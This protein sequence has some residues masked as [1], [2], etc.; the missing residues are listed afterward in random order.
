VETLF[1]VA[2]ARAAMAKTRY[3]VIVSDYQMPIENGIQFLKSLRG[4]GDHI[5]FIL[6]TGKGREEVVIEALNSGADFY[7]QK[8][9]E[10]TPLYVELEH[11]IRGVVRRHDAEMR[12]QESENRFEQLAEQGRIVTWEVNAHGIFTYVNQ[13]SKAVWGYD[14]GDLIGNSHF[15]D[16]HPQTGQEEFKRS[17]FAVFERKEKLH[18]V[19]N[20]VQTKA[21]ETIWVVT[22]GVPILNANGELKGYRGNDVDATARI[23]AESALKDKEA[24]FRAFFASIGDL[25]LVGTPDGRILFGNDAVRRKLG[26]TPEDLASMHMLDLHPADRRGE[27][28]AIFGA[29]FRGE[30]DHCPLPLAHKNGTLMPAETRVWFGRWDGKD[31]IFGISKDLTSQMEAQQMF[32]RLFRHNP[33]PMAVSRASGEGFSFNSRSLGN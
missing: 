24:N 14:P 4:R 25:I 31:C 13:V 20:P 28:E 12:L 26:Y 19:V 15:Y 7:L 1:S 18:D 23:Q 17:V 29:M 8:G 32:E 10:P 6:L 33:C 9:G 21:G 2:S 22:N 30:R 5:P 27:A 11:R 3:D 16:L